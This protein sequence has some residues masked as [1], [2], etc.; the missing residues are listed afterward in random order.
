MNK[1]AVVFVIVVVGFLVF[2]S[3]Q[4]KMTD[5]PM[6]N[7]IIVTPIEHASGI[8]TIDRLVVYTDPVGD[9]ARYDGKPAP[10]IILLTDI[11]G[12]HLDPAVL[13]ALSGADVTLVMPEAVATEL[14]QNIPGLR[15]VMANGDSKEILGAMIE[16][17]PMY[18]NPEA[19]NKD[20]HI[21]GRGN[22]YLINFGG[23]RVYV[24]GDTAAIPEMKALTNIDVALV[25]MNLPYTMG[26]EEAAEAVLAF[27]PNRVYPYHYRG[28]DGL[29][30]VEKFK[31]LVNA[32]NA[33][34]E[35]MLL[36]WYP[37]I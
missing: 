10:N 33:G 20:F 17:L 31:T 11:H 13:E 4:K 3:W 1:I 32:G 21:K 37:E 28:P 18:N 36:D 19:E 29:S 27:A 23:R 2:M 12:D 5:T 26:V 8:I 14:P 24:A 6:A 7:K 22:G 15:V 25:P 35:V 34:I 9:I 30:D 16:A